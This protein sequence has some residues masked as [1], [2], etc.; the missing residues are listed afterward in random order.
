MKL[1][2]KEKN[3]NTFKNIRNELMNQIRKAKIKAIEEGINAQT[4][5]LDKE[6]PRTKEFYKFKEMY[7]LKEKNLVDANKTAYN[8]LKIWKAVGYEVFELKSKHFKRKEP[9][10]LADSDITVFF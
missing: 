7:T 6:T 4:I 8:L 9:K 3:I 5:I 1:T 10:L 2:K